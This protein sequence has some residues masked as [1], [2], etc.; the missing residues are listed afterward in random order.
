MIKCKLRILMAI[1]EVNQKELS[2]ATGIRPN[3]IS[4]YVNNTYTT[5]NKD[6]LEIL[7]N[8]FEC[9]VE[10]IFENVKE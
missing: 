6:H 2:E 3:T 4:G 10:D 1:K 5:I 9:S 8:F 7:C